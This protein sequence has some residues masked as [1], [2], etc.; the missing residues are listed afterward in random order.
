MKRLILSAALGAA[1]FCGAWSAAPGMKTP[2][3]EKVTP[4]NAWRE[5][6]R[7]Q[8]AR[9]AWLNLNGLWEYAVTAESPAIP[10][11]WDGEIQSARE[12]AEQSEQVAGL[13]RLFGRDPI[14]RQAGEAGLLKRWKQE[15]RAMMR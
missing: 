15:Y 9:D 11:K 5:Y 6:P 13:K 10:E 7:P 4:E 12:A 2:W 14:K 1:S 3:G 8:M